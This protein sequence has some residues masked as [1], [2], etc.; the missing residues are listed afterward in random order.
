MGPRIFGF[1]N[2]A[3]LNGDHHANAPGNF[4]DITHATAPPANE[5]REP[6]ARMQQ[7]IQGPLDLKRSSDRENGPLL[8]GVL[9]LFFG[10]MRSVM[11]F[12]FMDFRLGLI[13]GLVGLGLN[14]RLGAVTCLLGG[15][16]GCLGSILGGRFD[17]SYRRTRQRHCKNQCQKFVHKY[18][19]SR[20]NWRNRRPRMLPMPSGAD[21]ER[22]R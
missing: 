15:L 18:C 20:C 13:D 12:S 17:L 6:A 22:M 2:S 1:Q 8:R 19:A 16:G 5:I 10:S 7:V 4:A 14:A 21:N 11:R 9:D 3:L